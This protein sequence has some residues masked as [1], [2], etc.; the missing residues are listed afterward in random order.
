ML[1]TIV[2][3]TLL[4]ATA[5]LVLVTGSIQAS[6]SDDQIA[7]R[8]SLMKGIG[9]AMGGLKAVATGKAEMANGAG[10]AAAMNAFASVSASAFPA[11]SAGEKSKAKPEIWSKPDDFKAALGAFQRAAADLAAGGD[12]KANFG[13]L[14]KTCGGCHKVFRMAAK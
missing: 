6:A 14:G 9:G 8:Q 13:A 3:G 7:Y 11:G 2:K 4:A 5:A 12:F 1:K 10:W